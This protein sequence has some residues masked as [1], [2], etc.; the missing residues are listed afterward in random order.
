MTSKSDGEII[1]V[2]PMRGNIEASTLPEDD[3]LE[4][5]RYMELALAQAQ[6][7]QAIGEVPVGAILVAPDGTVVATGYNRTI[8]DHDASAHAEIVAIRQAGQKL[9]NYRLPKLRLYVTLEPCCMCIMAAI[10]AR[11]AQVIFGTT[12]PRTGACG[13]VFNISGDFRHNHHLEVIAHVK[14]SEC[15]RLLQLFFRQRRAA[16]K[17][18][19]K[20]AKLQEAQSQFDSSTI[21]KL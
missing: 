15:A 14:Q 6:Q 19:K 2:L 8:I 3:R 21:R 18:A 10:H 9:R 1:T 12:D 20:Q 7:A 16:Q 17:Q 4:H 11:V 5:E 13:S